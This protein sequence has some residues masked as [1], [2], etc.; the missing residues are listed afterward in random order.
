MS[1]ERWRRV[2]ELFHSALE[3]GPAER[4]AFLT[5][6]CAGDEALR[7]EVEKLIAAHEKDGSFIDSPAY[8]DTELLVDRQAV[9]TSGQSLGPYK[10]INLLGRGGMGEVYLA[11]DSRL[12]RKVALKLLHSELTIDQDRLRRFRQ[13]AHAASA[14]NHPNILT[15]YEIGQADSIHFI[16]TEYVE[17]QTLRERMSDTRMKLR[18]V[19]D[20]AIQGASALAAAHQAGIVH[21]DI[22]PENIM[23]RTDGYVK[24]LDFGLAKLTEQGGT[25]DLEEPTASLVKTGAGIVMG[26]INYMSPEQAE[27]RRVDHRTD[28]FSLGVVLYEMLTGKRPF[29]GKSAIDTLHSIINEEPRPAIELN[30]QLPPEVMDILAKAMAKAPGERYRHAGDFELDLRRLKRAVETNSL[31]SSQVKA[32]AIIKPRGWRATSMLAALGALLILGVAVAGWMLNRSRRQPV[33]EAASAPLGRVTLAPI[34]VDQGYEGEPTFSPDGQTIAYVS[35]RTGNFEIF[36]K[37]VTGGPDINLTNNP[38]DDMQPSFSPDGKQIAFVSSRSGEYNCLCFFLYGTEQPLMGGAIWVMP[39]FG[40]SPRRIVESGTF[41]SWSSDGSSI[42]YS[43]GPW[44]GQKIYRVPSIGGNPEEIPIKSQ[45]APYLAYPSYSP[46][47]RWIA[48]EANN[49]VF[50]VSSKGGEPQKIV[51][52][53]HP[54]WGADSGAI[55][56]SNV[57]AGKNYSLWQLPFSSAEGK[58]SGNP[59]PLTVGRG[60]DSQA[61]VSRDGKLIA[62]A[63][64]DVSLNIESLPF[65]AETPRNMGAPQPVTSGSDRIYFHSISPDGMSSV[66]DSHR[67]ASSYIW[68]VDRG[69]A[70]VQLTSDPNFDDSD[71]DWSP[72]GRN[73]V[74]FREASR[75]EQG[76]IGIWVMA[77]DGANPQLLIKEA[78]APRWM[79]GGGAF[80]Y[81]SFADGQIYI[82]D[83]ASKSSRRITNE[84]GIYGIGVPS[85]EGKWLVYHSIAAGNVDVRA[86]PIEGGESRI[87]VDTRRQEFHPFVSPSGKW[88]Y[89]TLDHGNIYRVPGPAQNWRKA[90]PEKVTNFPETGLFLE[91]AH[92]SRDG[93]QLVYSRRRTTSDIWVMN[94]G[95]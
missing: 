5:E 26:T 16:A 50:I 38:A 6:A 82:Y 37:Q 20:V 67:G 79:P 31:P 59:S 10:V 68:R 52:G 69:S 85:P 12:S 56:Y 88:V 93:H 40:G 70:P 15:V 77:A 81:Q 74:F 61:T 2:D 66:Y 63:A 83:L 30:S 92:T 14:L 24:A 7:R 45:G 51:K 32:G 94:L 49:T 76:T 42:I 47:R 90:Q 29:G 36:L 60:Y 8:A 4:A 62:Y 23:V 80:V 41:P 53:K 89:Y 9:L 87:V 54:V 3:R 84:E 1:P 71:P 35:D 48:F 39:A 22:K 58:A 55:F 11:Q 72:D 17:G 27:A 18:E 34:T 21:R 65:D 75:G 64:L 95:T 25:G 19:L 78:G 86:I 43:S 73:I 28:I 57:E 91:D 33:S 13:E 44:H 46:D